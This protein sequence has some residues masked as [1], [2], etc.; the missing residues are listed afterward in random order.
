MFYRIRS[1]KKL[2][3]SMD[4]RDKARSDLYLAQLRTQSAPNTPGF[5]GPLTP[6][7]VS[8]SKDP[9]SQ[10]EEGASGVQFAS[11][12]FSSVSP[13]PFT[14]QAPPISRA[15]GYASSTRSNT[16]RL[17]SEGFMEAPFPTPTHVP[18]APGEHV[19]EAVPIPGA[20]AS[21]L[22]SPAPQQVTMSFGQAITAEH[23]IESPPTSPRLPSIMKRS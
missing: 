5:G 10:A 22:T 3:K 21:P 9:M 4:V 13:K 20:Y 16:P 23:R 18:A 17:P 6:R 11:Q 12:H 19:Y 8:E 2:R 1:K 15:A 14:L 7:F